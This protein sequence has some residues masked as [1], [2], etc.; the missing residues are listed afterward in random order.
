MTALNNIVDNIEQTIVQPC[1]T[2]GSE[3]F[4]VIGG[5]LLNWEL[6]NATLRMVCFTSN[7]SNMFG[8]SSSKTYVKVHTFFS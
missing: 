4:A 6:E 5:T 3:I 7:F 2:A 8:N 1:S